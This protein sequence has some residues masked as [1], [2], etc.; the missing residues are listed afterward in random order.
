[1]LN[2]AVGGATG[3]GT[4]IG[5]YFDLGPYTPTTKELFLRW[6]EWAVL[7]P[8]FRLHGS[9]GAGTHSPWSYDAE[10][11]RIYNDLSRLRLRFAPLIGRLWAESART[12]VPITRPLWLAFPGDAR[13]ATEDQQWML[14]EDILVAPVV[15]QGAT[16]RDVYFPQGCW[17]HGTTGERFTGARTAR[18]ASRLG[19][20]PFFFRCGQQP[21]AAPGAAGLPSARR[22]V[23]RR[24]FTIRLRR[25]DGARLRSARVTV[26]GRRVRVVR[27]GG[28]L[29]ARVNLRGRTGGRYVVRATVVTRDGARATETRRY[30]T[31]VPRRGR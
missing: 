9:V 29:T 23:S 14:G 25:P 7:S 22:C 19:E 3:F 12:G 24:S 11:V 2:R 8:V 1:M 18:V 21:V 4:D 30:R 10:T 27:R 5:G 13:A 17:E 6:A 20:L 16:S 28:R 31:C 26:D 15:Q